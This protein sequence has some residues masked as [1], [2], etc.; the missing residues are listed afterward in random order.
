MDKPLIPT[1]AELLSEIR[2]ERRK[3]EELLAT[4]TPDQMVTGGVDGD[5]SIKDILAHIATWEGWMRDW[6][7]S[8]VSGQAPRV[9]EE[10]NIDRMNAEAHARLRDMPLPK[11]LREFQRSYRQSLA[12]IEGLT[13]AQLRAE[14]LD[15]WPLGPLWSKVADNTS[16]HYR[17]HRLDI[18]KWLAKN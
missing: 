6:T 5:W 13:E 10:W 11:V 14:T 8:L 18:E 9:P 15:T 17:E 1:Q 12:L 16:W 4:L 3:L 2:E 7:T